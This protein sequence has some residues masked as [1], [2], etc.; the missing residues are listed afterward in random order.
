MLAG[1]AWDAERTN[2]LRQAEGINRQLQ[3]VSDVLFAA[4]ALQPGERC[5]TSGAARAHDPGS[6]ARGRPDGQVTGLDLNGPMLAAGAAYPVADG[7]APIE[8]LEADPVE[9]TAGADLR[10]RAVPLRRRCSSPT[11]RRLSPTSPGGRRRRAARRR[12]VGPPARVGHVPGA[13]RAA[14]A[15]ALGS[16]TTC[17]TPTARSRWATPIEIRAAARRRRLDRRRVGGAPALAPLRRRGRRRRR[18]ESSLDFGPT[19]IIT[20]DVDDEARARVIEAIAAAFERHYDGRRQRGP[21]RHRPRDDGA[22]PLVRCAV[23]PL[24][25][26]PGLHERVEV[27]V[28]A[29]RATLP[30][31]CSVRSSF[32]SWYGLEDVVADRAPPKPMLISSPLMLSSSAYRSCSRRSS[33]LAWSMVMALARFWSWLRSTWQLTR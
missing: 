2:W 23:G 21:R 13:L 16:R 24:P 14:A 11:R 5:S 25:A 10:R 12:H 9:W 31:S 32:T 19:R 8:W 3:P 33:S 17:P 4:A 1:E 6:G 20:Q 29:R 15:T 28:E 27:A 22:A 18:G 30:S 26:Q 7:A